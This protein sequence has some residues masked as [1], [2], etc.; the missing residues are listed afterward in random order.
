MIFLKKKRRLLDLLKTTVQMIDLIKSKNQ[1]EVINNCQEAVKTIADSLEGEL[2]EG[3][4][5]FNDLQTMYDLL[6]LI[7]QQQVDLTSE[8]IFKMKQ[9]LVLIVDKL[10][11]LIPVKL[12]IA[13]MPYKVTMWDSLASI[14]EA[15]KQDPDCTAKII[16]IPYYEIAADKTTSIYEGDLFPN[17]IP[18][19]PYD[20]YDLAKEEPDI[21]FIHNAYDQYN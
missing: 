8:L 12:N 3:E 18:I 10:D 7:D 15:A 19:I 13:F 11:K 5:V 2:A 1:S 20:E 4:T 9:L 16:P 17:D 14:Y 6:T 21:I